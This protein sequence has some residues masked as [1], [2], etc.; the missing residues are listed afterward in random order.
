[1]NICV[2]VAS[3]SLSFVKK[4]LDNDR[5]CI[6]RVD[7]NGRPPLYYCLI[8]FNKDMATL[9]FSHNPDLSIVDRFGLTIIDYAYY[10][11][12]PLFL[13]LVHTNSIEKIN[14]KIKSHGREF[15]DTLKLER[16]EDD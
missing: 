5:E 13:D 8:Y 3:N 6:N 12:Q 9:L 16:E 4:C 15:V 10:Y 1:M 11:N 14:S 7:I 2:Y